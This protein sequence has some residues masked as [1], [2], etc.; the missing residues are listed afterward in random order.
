MM[1]FMLDTK[2]KER[3]ITYDATLWEKIYYFWWV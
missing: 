1:F 3:R 2:L